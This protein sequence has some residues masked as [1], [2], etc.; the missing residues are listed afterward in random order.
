MI[1]SSKGSPT[2]PGSMTS[3]MNV[4][5]TC[6]ASLSR[7][8]NLELGVRGDIKH[9]CVCDVIVEKLVAGLQHCGLGIIHKWRQ[10]SRVRGCWILGQICVTSYMDAP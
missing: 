5:K 9:S 10:P 7:Q 1:Q 8:A 6:G 4:P 2:Y 3:F